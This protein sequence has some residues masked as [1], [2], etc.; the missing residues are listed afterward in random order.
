[1]NDNYPRTIE[2]CGEAMQ[3]ALNRIGQRRYQ[4]STNNCEHFVTYVMTGKPYCTQLD[5]RSYLFMFVVYSF[6]CLSDYKTIFLKR[7][8][9]IWPLIYN[10]CK[11]ICQKLSGIAL[12]N[13]M[14][15]ALLKVR[16][17]ITQS[18]FGNINMNKI[19]FLLKNIQTVLELV[20]LI[21]EVYYDIQLCRERSISR[22]FLVKQ[23]LKRVIS[24]VISFYFEN[25]GMSDII[26]GVAC[27][28]C[29]FECIL[30]LSIFS[31][32]NIL[33]PL[34]IDLVYDKQLWI[35]TARTLYD[36][37]VVILYNYL[38]RPYINEDVI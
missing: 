30:V 12:F 14:Q 19:S 36:I 26:K 37:V 31:S 34:I 29:T 25:Y 20:L 10:F 33:M 5:K 11:H 6:D 22:K 28:G 2:Q 15:R 9:S 18:A 27:A 38:F 16:E 23:I 3:R 8:K 4:L 13:S 24:S 21:R 17:I 7:E 32:I 1:M 35:E